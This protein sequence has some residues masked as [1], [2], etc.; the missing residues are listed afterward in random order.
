MRDHNGNVQIN[1]RRQD[2][3]IAVIGSGRIGGAYGSLWAKAGHAVTYGV[4]GP[5]GT[6]SKGVLEHSP[7]AKV[8]SIKEA[9]REAEVVL[10]AIPGSAVEGV[11]AN[12]ELNTKVVID[13]TNGGALGESPNRLQQLKPMARVVRAFNYYGFDLIGHSSFDGV[14][15]DAFLCGDDTDARGSVA[16]LALEA[17]FNP[18]DLGG[19]SNAV[20]Q[21]G[22]LA[23][24]FAL[25]Q[26]LGTRVLAFKVLH[27]P[28]GTK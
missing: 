12:L 15:A 14:Q 27:A 4:R 2:M 18:L 20:T 1:E 17:G 22:L 23:V 26:R 25:S 21:D 3:N 8:A 19:L 7:N 6:N 9:V 16:Q 5:Q 13:A 10:L 24:W 28:L 11:V